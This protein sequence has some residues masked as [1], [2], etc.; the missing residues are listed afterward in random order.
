M[1]A[2]NY[3]FMILDAT[4]KKLLNLL[5]NDASMTHK[6]LAAHLNLTVTPVY[7]RIKKLK[8]AGVIEAIQAKINRHK[9]GLGVMIICEVAVNSHTKESLE[10][11]EKEISKLNEVIE[12]F[13]VSGKHDYMLKVVE[14]SMDDYR[15]FLLNKLSKI[16]GVDNVNS[17]FVMHELKQNKYFQV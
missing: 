4:D 8:K 2:E 10:L 12:C 11:F 1:K 13:H 16:P 15:N 3:S 14:S 9:I 7:E 5:Q 17:T 6:Q